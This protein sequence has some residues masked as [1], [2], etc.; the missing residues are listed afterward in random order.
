VPNQNLKNAKLKEHIKA[1][2]EHQTLVE[3]L[4]EAD[5]SILVD[6]IKNSLEKVAITL[7]EYFKVIG[8]P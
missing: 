4:H 2:E 6:E 3:N 7:E 1:L 5:S 8:I